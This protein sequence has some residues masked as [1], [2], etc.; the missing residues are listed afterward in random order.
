MRIMHS[1]CTTWSL[2]ECLIISSEIFLQ[3]DF[4]NPDYEKFPKFRDV[5][6]FEAVLGPGDVLYLPMYW[7][8]K[9]DVFSV[10]SKH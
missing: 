9:N 8:V 6:G 5:K 10:K 1:F 7:W 4:D 3:V 2:V